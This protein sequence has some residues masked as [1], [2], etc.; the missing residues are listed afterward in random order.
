[1]HLSPETLSKLEQLGLASLYLFG[2]RAQGIER[3]DSDY[4]FGVIMKD[5]RVLSAGTQELYQNIYDLLQDAVNAK[6]NLDIV[7]LDR[8]PMQLRYHVI[9]YGKVLFDSDPRRRGNFIERT[10][11]E[12]ADF[13][14]HRRRFEEAILARIP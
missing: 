12:H 9:R 5:P 11:I 4:D 1:M 10:L 2:S 3:K 13:E 7:F 14:P 6:V 8:A